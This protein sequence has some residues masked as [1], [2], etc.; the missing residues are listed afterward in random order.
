MPWDMER[1]RHNAFYGIQ[2]HAC[3]VLWDKDINGVLVFDIQHPFRGVLD[4][5]T[6]VLQLPAG[7]KITR[8]KT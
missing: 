1:G 2:L 3:M 7:V 8:E 4:G 6:P 5:D